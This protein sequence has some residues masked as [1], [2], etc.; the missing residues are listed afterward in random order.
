MQTS[1]PDLM[2]LSGESQATYDMYGPE[3]KKPGSFASNCILARRLVERG[4]PFIQLFQGLDAKLTGVEKT[5]VVK[6]VLA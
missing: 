2:D 1:V 4:V 6:E 3:S 5:R